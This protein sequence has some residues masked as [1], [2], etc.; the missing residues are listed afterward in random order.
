MNPVNI[1]GLG[2]GPCDLT[3]QQIDLIMSAEILIGG[4]RH[5]SYFKESKA[6]KKKIKKNIREIT[7][8][9]KENAGKK[10]IVILASGDPLF[11]GIG[12]LII[13]AVGKDMVKIYPNI[14]S[15]GAA[16]A[17]IKEPWHDAF[18][19]SLHGRLDEGAL[20]FALANGKKI[21]ILTDPVRTPAWLASFMIK[22]SFENFEFFVLEKMGAKD[23]KIIG[24][25]IYEASRMEFE[26]PNV[27][28]LLRNKNNKKPLVFLGAD[29]KFY[30]H[31]KGLITKPEIRAIAL[32]KLALKED[33]IL[34]DLGAG[35]GSVSIEASLFIKKGKIFAIEKNHNRIKQIQANRKKFK[36]P[37]LEIIEADLPYGLESLPAPDRIFIGGGGKKL[38]GIIEKSAKFLKKDGIIVINT[39]LL[40]NMEKP[41][42]LLKNLGFETDMIQVQINSASP[43]PWGQRFKAQNPVWIITGLKKTDLS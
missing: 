38:C 14:T 43:M 12:S 22:K 37:N 4:E 41:F 10:N 18:L 11:Y 33:H 42:A 24:C 34:W 27:V 23:E 13:K 16:F 6:I 21:G 30:E 35:S 19:I 9:V 5:L 26:E 29:E 20:G 2:L 25:D 1:I 28:I 31:E 36:I 40:Q 17:R 7:G 39:V 32:S 15:F 3:K 8:F